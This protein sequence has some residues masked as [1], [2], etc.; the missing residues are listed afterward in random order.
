MPTT[1]SPGTDRTCAAPSVASKHVKQPGV[2]QQ[3]ALVVGQPSVRIVLLETPVLMGH[4]M[5]DAT[6]H[7]PQPALP[8]SVDDG[9]WP[10]I[11]GQDRLSTQ[12]AG[13]PTVLAWV[14]R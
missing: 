10:L 14:E 2:R 1:K 11:T 9:T 4:Q 5:T 8:M 13:H 6:K 3:S 7:L 12:D